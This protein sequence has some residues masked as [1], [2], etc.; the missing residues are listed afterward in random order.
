MN[1][2]VLLASTI[3]AIAKRL[4]DV[5]E[6]N[7]ATP[8]LFEQGASVIRE[9]ENG[10]YE[11]F[12]VE[13][14]FLVGEYQNLISQIR[15][16]KSLR[17]LFIVVYAPSNID[18]E[19]LSL[20]NGANA[21]LSAPFSDAGIYALFK[22]AFGLPK[23]AML[24][25]GTPQEEFT[26]ALKSLG[27]DLRVFLTA[28][29]ALS[30]QGPEI[31]D[32]IICEY[33][34]SGMNAIEFIQ[35]INDSDRLKGLPVVVA[36]GGRNVDAIE[37]IIKAEAF[38]VIL[39]PFASPHNLKKIQD[40][41]PLPPRGR[42]LRALVVDDS[43]TIRELISG[44]FK[45]L[46]YHVVTAENGFEGYKAVE[47]LKPDIITSDYDMP[48]LN[49]WEFCTEIRDHESYKD[50]P[51]IM[52]TTR[53]TELDQKKGEI[54]GVSAYLTKP[55]Q[56]NDL[57]A[58]VDMAINNAKI[59]KEQETIAKFVA[60]DTIR[61]VNDMIDGG[62][63]VKKGENKFITVL[64]SDI[65]EFS[66]KCEKFS[67]R[68]IVK[69]LN[70]YFDLMVEVLSK[71]DA[72]IDKF[73]G[74]AIVARFDSGHPETDA[75][76]AILA[77][78]EMCTELKKFNLD[79]FEEIQCRIGINSGEV[80]LG[81]LGCERHRLEYAMIGDNVNIGQ[82]LESAAPKQ[83]VMFSEATYDLV[84]KY[85]VVGELQEVEVKG[86]K[87]KVPAYILDGVVSGNNS[88]AESGVNGK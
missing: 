65:C 41:F 87:E 14:N 24:V 88:L 57:K 10:N 82:R 4:A 12:L 2:R 3:G 38:D 84:K 32:F 42:R 55:F 63:D 68:K 31:P 15:E 62:G 85:V 28:E 54:L 1:K 53:A 69:L 40:H 29:E 52:I 45:E 76:N 83:G 16:N 79:S 56:K 77:A 48:V 51:I 21:V 8:T 7:G 43:P 37:E 72:I 30:D 17:D 23:Q 5:C 35:K 25:S 46:D 78:W 44:M 71:Y 9:L 70:T 86:K 80:I 26:L 60:A 22:R 67:A 59:K 74:D 47:R 20:T 61:A 19:Q 50:I 73:I 27:Y 34:L 13:H 64:F 18:D 11:L 36:Y 58:S 39:T 6:R 75:R 49:G 33:D 81:S 66:P